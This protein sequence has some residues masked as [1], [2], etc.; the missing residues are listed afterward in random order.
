M[1]ALTPSILESSVYHVKVPIYVEAHRMSTDN[2]YGFDDQFVMLVKV[3]LHRNP[4]LCNVNQVVSAE[5]FKDFKVF[6]NASRL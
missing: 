6:S 5:I 4:A 1:P 2:E 3:V